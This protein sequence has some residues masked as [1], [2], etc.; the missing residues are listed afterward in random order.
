MAVDVNPEAVRCARINALLNH[1]EDRIDVRLGDLFAP[2]GD[3]RFDLILF[4]P[5][6]FRGQPRTRLDLA[7]RSPDVLERFAAQLGGH[8]TGSGRAVL[9][10]STAGEWKAALDAL[11]QN[12]FAARPFSRQDLIS[13][14]F[15][16]YLV[17]AQVGH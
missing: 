11:K 7:W 4:N 12:G 1:L 13:E 8:L 6:F 9:I 14:V 16:A 17:E 15:T 3:Q 10:L 2:V 5:P